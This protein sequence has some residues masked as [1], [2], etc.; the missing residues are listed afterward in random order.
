[1][2]G[3]HLDS[4][5]D[6]NEICGD[7]LLIKYQCDDG[8]RKSGDGCSSNCLIEKGWSCV[9]SS[10]GSV[11]TLTAELTITLKMAHKYAR[12]NKL[13]LVLKM[14]LDLQVDNSNF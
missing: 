10:N 3:Y 2:T 4:T 14:S 1:M 7:G 12:R 5:G 6:C 11:C 8:N 9:N 13:L